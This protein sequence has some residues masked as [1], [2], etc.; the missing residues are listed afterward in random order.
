MDPDPFPSDEEPE[1]GDI[2]MDKPSDLRQLAAN[3]QNPGRRDPDDAGTFT[4]GRLHRIY[5]IAETRL[6][7]NDS[8][9]RGIN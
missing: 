1:E 5:L 9:Y 8:R 4:L 7:A 2:L 3:I 6:V